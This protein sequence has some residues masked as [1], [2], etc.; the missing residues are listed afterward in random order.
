MGKKYYIG[1]NLKMLSEYSK[2]ELPVYTRDCDFELVEA[3]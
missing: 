2:N 1:E 3:R